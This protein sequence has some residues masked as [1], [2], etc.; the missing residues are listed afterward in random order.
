MSTTNATHAYCPACKGNA[1]PL[2]R[3]GTYTKHRRALPGSWSGRTE[4]CPASGD[5]PTEASVARWITWEVSSATNAATHCAANL[6]AAR[7]TLAAAEAAD[8]EARAR[9]DA[10]GRVIA[11]RK[12]SP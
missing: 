7:A 3:D 8:T 11:A 5:V 1:V 9:L 6:T 12:A 4:Q 2:K 10:I